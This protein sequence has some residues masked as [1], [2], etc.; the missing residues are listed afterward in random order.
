MHIFIEPIVFR[1]SGARES[2]DIKHL[3]AIKK[4][5]ATER[6]YSAF[7]FASLVNIQTPYAALWNPVVR[8]SMKVVTKTRF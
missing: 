1:I 7:N 3:G 2:K 6:T 5:D 8:D 4:A